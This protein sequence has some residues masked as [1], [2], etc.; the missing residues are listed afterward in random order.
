MREPNETVAHVQQTLQCMG[1]RTETPLKLRVAHQTTFS[2]TT[3][4]Y[5]SDCLLPLENY[6]KQPHRDV[7]L[8]QLSQPRPNH[9]FLEMHALAA[10]LSA[11]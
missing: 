4:N 8:T 1:E 11:D 2:S 3:G 5:R 10:M 9:M 7:Y 6:S